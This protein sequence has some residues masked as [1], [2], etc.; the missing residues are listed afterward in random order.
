[1]LESIPLP[2]D[3]LY[4]T[5]FFA[6]LIL[7]VW[8]GLRVYRMH[9]VEI[10][11]ERLSGEIENL[12]NRETWLNEDGEAYKGDVARLQKEKEGRWQEVPQL[13]PNSQ[14]YARFLKA[15]GRTRE[16]VGPHP[17]MVFSIDAQKLKAAIEEK[18]RAINETQKKLTA[19]ER[20]LVSTARDIT[21]SEI[22][23]RAKCRE[24]DEV[25]RFIRFQ[26]NIGM[27]MAVT[28]LLSSC[29]GAYNWY[30]KTQ[31]YQDAIKKIEAETKSGKDE[32]GGACVD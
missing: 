18:H 5:A 14:E 21:I 28:G 7:L 32:K 22:Q 31:K 6:G 17:P 1:M 30:A 26:M 27:V 29:F 12:H 11:K 19:T 23:L 2:T 4:K 20:K 3:N 25:K 16:M 13:D 9:Q 24:N 15:T 10:E 8:S